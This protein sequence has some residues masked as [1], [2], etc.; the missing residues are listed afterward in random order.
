MPE[1]QGQSTENAPETN[2][3]SNAAENSE[4]MQVADGAA[5]SEAAGTSDGER[6]EMVIKSDFLVYVPHQIFHHQIE[7][8]NKRNETKRKALGQLNH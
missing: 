6:R 1:N 7:S 3:T 4:P 2:N 8:E 5:T